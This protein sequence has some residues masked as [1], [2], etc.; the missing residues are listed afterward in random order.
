MIKD[1]VPLAIRIEEGAILFALI[2]VKIRKL[3]NL[4]G[5]ECVCFR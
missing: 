3:K 5:V 1:N 2:V 4:L